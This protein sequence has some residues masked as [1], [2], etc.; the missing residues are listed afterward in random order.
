MKGY[1]K[2]GLYLKSGLYS[3]VTF[4]G[5]Y[6]MAFNTDMTVPEYLLKPFMSQLCNI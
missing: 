3:E 1:L 6:L 5:F 2:C 4:N